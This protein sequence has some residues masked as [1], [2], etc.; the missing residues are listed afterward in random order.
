MVYLEF[1]PAVSALIDKDGKIVA[2]QLGHTRFPVYSGQAE[3]VVFHRAV[4]PALKLRAEAL[5]VELSEGH[6]R[7]DII[8]TIVH[9]AL[10]VSLDK[11]DVPG[12]PG[13]E[14]FVD[15]ITKEVLESIREV[16]SIPEVPGRAKKMRAAYL[17]GS[18]RLVRL[19]RRPAYVRSYRRYHE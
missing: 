5:G 2:Y 19:H 18:L 4:I 6:I 9:E 11:I 8:E 10:H 7:D 12:T 16:S 15:K 1:L 3:A 14:A 17:G 13:E